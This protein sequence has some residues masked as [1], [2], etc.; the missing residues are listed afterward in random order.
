MSNSSCTCDLRQ[1]QI[2]QLVSFASSRMEIDVTLQ[3]IVREDIVRLGMCGQYVTSTTS[4]IDRV[5]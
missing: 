2:R 3:E 5:I 1:V 4:T